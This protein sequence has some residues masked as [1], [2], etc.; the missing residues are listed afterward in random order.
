M[1]Y[2]VNDGA[3]Y[4]ISRITDKNV[5][6]IENA[7]IYRWPPTALELVDDDLE[8]RIAQHQALSLMHRVAQLARAYQNGEVDNLIKC[9]INLEAHDMI[10]GPA[11]TK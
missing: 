4:T 2:Y 10:L 1:N 9:A 8:K 11:P 5:E 6:F 7:N 3:A